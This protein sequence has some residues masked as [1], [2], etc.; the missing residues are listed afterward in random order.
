MAKNLSAQ[1]VVDLPVAMGAPVKSAA[2]ISRGRRKIFTR[3]RSPFYSMRARPES[4]TRPALPK[5]NQAHA[6]QFATRRS[7]RLS[8]RGSRRPRI[9]TKAFPAKVV[10]AQPSPG[11][12]D[13]RALIG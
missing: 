12:A 11:G 4:Q 9:Q 2:N 7:S 8:K 1:L 5:R 3:K 13:T 10:M 6:A